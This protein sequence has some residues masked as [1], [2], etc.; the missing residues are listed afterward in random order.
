[1]FFYI[2]LFDDTIDDRK[3][4]TEIRL[5]YAS[6]YGKR[7]FRIYAAKESG[8]VLHDW[9]RRHVY[10]ASS[11]VCFQSGYAE[12]GSHVLGGAGGG[13]FEI[14]KPLTYEEE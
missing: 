6:V 4:Q 2:F 8:H 10:G 5:R 1:M 9:Q 12:P 13:I 11:Q 3:T 7:G 14:K